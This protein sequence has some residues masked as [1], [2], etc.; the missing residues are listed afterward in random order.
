M[1]TMTIS[2]WPGTLSKSLKNNKK[3]A[4]AKYFQLATIREGQPACRTVVFRG[5]H[6]DSNN[7]TFITDIR[8]VLGN[9]A[10][11]EICQWLCILLC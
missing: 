8:Y 10:G 1:T 4:Y 11:I 6:E 2:P 7:I 5:F 9:L 3:L